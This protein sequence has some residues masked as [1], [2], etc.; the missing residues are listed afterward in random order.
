ALQAFAQLFTWTSACEFDRNI[1]VWAQSSQANHAFSKVKNT[2]YV[3]HLEQ[4]DFAAFGHARSIDHQMHGFLNAHKVADHIP[5][6]DGNWPAVVDLLIESRDDAPTAAKHIAKAHGCEK[7]F[8]VR[9]LRKHLDDE[10][11]NALAF[12]HRTD[13]LHSLIR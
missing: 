10:F 1:N 2:N 5:I 6:C 13:W 9:S 4:E 11:A 3:T 8:I 12:T 7:R